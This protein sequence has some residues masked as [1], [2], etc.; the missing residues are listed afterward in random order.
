[1]QASDFTPFE[2]VGFRSQ[3]QLAARLA[4]LLGM[5]AHIV[6]LNTDGTIGRE[7]TMISIK[8]EMVAQGFV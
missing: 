4:Q 1:M 7:Q 8:Q 6:S 2:A 5:P 3:Q